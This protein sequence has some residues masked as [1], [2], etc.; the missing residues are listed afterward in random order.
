[1]ELLFSYGT[2]RSK[3]IQMQIF[4]KVLSGTPDQILGYKLKSLQIEEEFGMA[5]YV[6]AIPSENLTENIHGVAFEIS[7][8]DLLKVDQF[9]SNSYKRVQV[10]LKSGRTAWIYT[11][12]K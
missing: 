9:E 11:E 3:Q 4:N 7:N 6:V 1:M 8:T 12:N 2:L 10:K 5:D